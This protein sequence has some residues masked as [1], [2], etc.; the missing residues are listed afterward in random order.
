VLTRLRDVARRGDMRLIY[1]D[2]ATFCASPPVQRSSSPL[3]QPHAT[4]SAKHCTRSVLG[5][6]D[7]GTQQLETAAY[8]H[9]TTREVFVSFIDQMLQRSATAPLTLIV[10]DNTHIHH[11]V[12]PDVLDRWLIDHHTL[13]FYL[14]PYSP[15]LNLIEIVW[16]KLKYHWRRFVTWSRESF[17]A[18]LS[19]LLGGYGREFQV[20][21][22]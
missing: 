5:A 22:L 19:K 20:D 8:A 7:F 4:E 12:P 21:F 16:K 14:P 9:T 13:L 10:L 3:G 11:H 18:E 6:L 1:Y 17:E 15:E 2:E